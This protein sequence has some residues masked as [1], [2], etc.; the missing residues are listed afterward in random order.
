[1]ALRTYVIIGVGLVAAIVI[2]TLAFASVATFEPPPRPQFPYWTEGK[3]MPTPRTEVAGAAIDMKVYIVGGFDSAGRAVPT[4]EAY[5]SIS[6]SWSRA[7]SLPLP[8]H[9]AGAAS[10]GGKL[11]VV[12]GYFADRT[13]S[14]RLIVY[15]PETNKWE[16]LSPM[17]TARG[18][19]TTNFVNGTLYAV[20]GVNGAFGALEVPTAINEAYDP[21]TDTWT[22]KEPMPTPRQHL[23]SASFDGKLFVIGG[24]IDSLTSN[25][26][27]NEA[28]DPAL[29]RWTKLQLMPS[30][31]GGLAA[32]VSFTDGWIYVFGG[33]AP[34]GTFSITER[35]SPHGDVWESVIDMPNR[36]HGLAAVDIGSEIYVI[37]GGPKPGLT[38]GDF[39]QILHTPFSAG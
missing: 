30:K 5:D 11:Y 36:R 37:G 25:L 24:R 6:D 15:D 12:G 18:A 4:V 17:P 1:M 34:S 16:E 14:D 29:D 21:S 10:Y 26:D 31:R 39:N 9:H 20:G 2:A 28:Y 22:T 8:L 32:A 7:A 19:L 27:A 23:A 38:V 33:E 3:P 35:Y 13:P